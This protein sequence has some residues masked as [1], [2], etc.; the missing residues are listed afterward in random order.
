MRYTEEEKCEFLR[1]FYKNN[2]NAYRARQEYRQLYP[3]LPLPAKN[4]FRNIERG[5]R[6]RK[7]IKRKPREVTRN[8]DKELDI[9][10]FFEGRYD[11]IVRILLFS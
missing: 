1:L 2:S 4:T 9:L 10:L 8:L 7:S 6:M 11:Y 3:D 5:F